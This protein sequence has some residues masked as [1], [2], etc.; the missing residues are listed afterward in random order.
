MADWDLVLTNGRLATM[1][2]D[3][4]GT[5]DNGAVAI[6]DGRIAWVGPVATL[7]G[8]EARQTLDLGGRWVTPGL[9][10]CHT[11]LVYAGNR[12][13][14]FAMRLGGATY[15]E[16][17]A[18]GGGIRTS[19]VA[20]RAAGEDALFAAALPRLKALLAEGVTTVEVKSGYGLD[21]DTELRM[22]RVA[23]RLGE[24]VPVSVTA[25]FLG[26]HTVPAEFA[27]DRAGYVDLV[28]TVM[29]EAA[30]EKLCDAT[31]VCYDPIGFD[32]AESERML[33][34][35]AQLGLPV[36]LH[37]GQFA[38]QGGG[39]LAA[40]FRALSADHVEHLT[41]DDVAAMAAAGTVAVLL[42]GAFYYLRETQ[43]PP[44]ELLRRAGV[45]LAVAT[46]HNPGSSPLLS[47]ILAMNMAS[48]LFGLTPVETLAGVTRNAARALGLAHDRGTI[49]AGK[50]ADL[51]IWSIDDPGE[52]AAAIGG[53]VAAA[54]IQG[55]RIVT[56]TGLEPTRPR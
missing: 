15:V 55:G 11:H 44:V 50:R 34:A 25:T 13:G 4:Y 51:A 27:A 18:A 6:A 24:S 16:I 10:D 56:G 47:L 43:K 36:K 31:D 40:E 32:R 21:R 22:L 20:T 5:I 30:A 38:A 26:G 19:V 14:E 2:G 49:A 48:V 37:T 28:C 53:R 23:R 17:A 1:A 35:A 3:G 9:I 46:D 29:A 52:L 7:A 45:P 33:S 12:A 39:R 8:R 54:T 41:R 42:P